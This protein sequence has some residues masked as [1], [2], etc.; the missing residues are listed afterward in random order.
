MQLDLTATPHASDTEFIRLKLREYN[1]SHVECGLVQELAV[2]ARDDAKKITGGIVALTWG[3]WLQIQLLWVD[4]PSRGNGSGSQL[5]LAAERE[6]KKRGCRFSLI[7]TFNFQAIGFY[8]RKGYEVKMTLDAFPVNQQR[9]YLT[10]E[11]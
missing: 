6:A 2:F 10:K 8:L 4:Q 11:I 9:Y 5:L 1:Q 7:D 3:N